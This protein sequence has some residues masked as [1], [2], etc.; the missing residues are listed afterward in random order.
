[1]D[2]D[3][4]GVDKDVLSRLFDGLRNSDG[5]DATRQTVEELKDAEHLIERAAYTRLAKSLNQ[6]GRQTGGP[7][8]LVFSTSRGAEPLGAQLL[9]L[10][11]DEGFSDE[12]LEIV[13]S[14]L[15]FN[16]LD[17]ER[18]SIF[19]SNPEIPTT[20]VPA[21]PSAAR[22][23]VI[24]AGFLTRA[25]AFEYLE[26]V[27]SKIGDPIPLSE[28]GTIADNI[29]TILD[30]LRDKHGSDV[31]LASSLVDY[32]DRV[33]LSSKDEDALRRLGY[34]KDNNGRE[35]IVGAMEYYIKQWQKSAND[36]NPRSLAIQDI[37]EEEFDIEGAFPF[38]SFYEASGLS[39]E[40]MTDLIR[41]VRQNEGEGMRVFVR[42]QYEDTQEMLKSMGVE[43]LGLIRGF[44]MPTSHPDYE[45]LK[46]IDD[47]TDGDDLT[48]FGIDSVHMMRP[49]SSWSTDTQ[50]ALRFSK[51]TDQLDEERREV[52][53]VAEVP[54]EQIFGTAINGNGCLDEYEVVVLGKPTETRMYSSDV[55]RQI[56]RD[57]TVPEDTE[58][59]LDSEWLNLEVPSPLNSPE[60]TSLS[61]PVSLSRGDIKDASTEELRSIPRPD[62][63][64]GEPN[65]TLAEAF[66]SLIEMDLE[67]HSP[68]DSEFIYSVRLNEEPDPF[69]EVPA[70][71]ESAQ[72][73]ADQFGGQI[74]LRDGRTAEVRINRVTRETAMMSMA[75][76][77]YVDGEFAGRSERTFG[78]DASDGQLVVIHDSLFVEPDYQ[79]SGIGRAFN[80]QFEQVYK[81]YG[82][83]RIITSGE[84]RQGKEA[85]DVTPSPK[86]DWRGGT[87]W[88]RQGFDWYNE[89]SRQ[90]F[91]DALRPLTGF[92]EESITH[93]ELI[94]LNADELRARIPDGVYVEGLSPGEAPSLLDKY[95]IGY[96]ESVDAWISFI[97]SLMQSSSEDFDS[98]TR[99]VPADLLRW[100]GADYYFSGQ[101]LGFLYT[102]KVL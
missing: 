55:A 36:A 58:G 93:E 68:D 74:K 73:I 92:G 22:D 19:F 72:T 37:V 27:G 71:R 12:Q 4:N 13:E 86:D 26:D 18:Y 76:E 87:H 100:E 44:T 52:I 40:M 20:L 16:P 81:Q 17:D 57:D 101:D 89:D 21:F 8:D 25:T 60:Q 99:V 67:N 1:M 5:I 77:F 7:D 98:P 11:R 42:A 97:S 10:L 53:V 90:E 70:D 61:R 50:T 39:P 96:F 9:N 30:S 48:E 66:D 47:A 62:S 85:D 46:G 41:L 49:L 102:K 82:V 31:I 32:V 24:D 43:R 64:T 51:N 56:N 6:I 83:A 45:I 63:R 75:V 59:G 95:E 15:G 54:R 69:T 14:F 34:V 29:K 33:A 28:D 2:G 91:L 79:K 35:A 23:S 94:S 38:D 78:R 88:P 84:S 65:Q 80:S 3:E